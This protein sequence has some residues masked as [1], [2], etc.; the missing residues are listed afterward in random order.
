MC[1]LLIYLWITSLI[2]AELSTKILYFVYQ[3]VDKTIYTW[4]NCG[5]STIESVDNVIISTDSTHL[6]KYNEGA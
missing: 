2:K 6:V 4:I 5:F 3:S 1:I